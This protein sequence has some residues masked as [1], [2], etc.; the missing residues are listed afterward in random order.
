MSILHSE[1]TA[2]I[3]GHGGLISSRLPAV[4]PLDPEDFEVVVAMRWERWNWSSISPPTPET[5]IIGGQRSYRYRCLSSGFDQ[6]AVTR[7]TFAQSINQ[8]RRAQIR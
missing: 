5:R 7:S 1:K 4:L 3:A 6:P 8:L 2:R